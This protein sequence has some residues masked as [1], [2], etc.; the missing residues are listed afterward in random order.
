MK[1]LSSR[2]HSTP[3]RWAWKFLYIIGVLACFGVV[4]ARADTTEIVT[5]AN[6]FVLRSAATA[7]QTDSET[8]SSKGLNDSNS[9]FVYLRFDL[10]SFLATH[11]VS[12]ITAVN[13]RIVKKSAN[14]ASATVLGLN[15]T[16][17]GTNN[18]DNVWTN[19]MTWNNQPA[20]TAAPNDLPKADT[21]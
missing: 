5:S 1:R 8:L 13:L 11:T 7:D 9:R 21:A 16:I 12:G 6:A 2:M 17:G 14:A 4:T 20:K 3:T 15:S 10:A 18:F 19:I